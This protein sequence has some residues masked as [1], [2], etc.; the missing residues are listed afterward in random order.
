MWG[1]YQIHCAELCDTTYIGWINRAL[2]NRIAGHKQASFKK[3]IEYRFS[4]TC[5][6]H[7]HLLDSDNWNYCKIP[8]IYRVHLLHFNCSCNSSE[9]TSLAKTIVTFVTKLICE[10]KPSVFK[11]L[12]R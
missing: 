12:V 11:S 8:R 10:K 2:K 1:L 4:L 9:I 7:N 6:T 5:I 3:H